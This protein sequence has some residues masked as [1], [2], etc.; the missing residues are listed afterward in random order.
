M[1]QRG[2]T[3][4]ELMVSTALSLTILA[5]TLAAWMQARRSYSSCAA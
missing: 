1:T 3:L 2:F 5:G 4:V